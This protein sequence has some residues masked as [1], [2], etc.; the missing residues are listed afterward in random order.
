MACGNWRNNGVY[1]CTGYVIYLYIYI[2]LELKYSSIASK[3]RA[4]LVGPFGFGVDT[5]P[6]KREF[7]YRDDSWLQPEAQDMLLQN[8]PMTSLCDDRTN[9]LEKHEKGRSAKQALLKFLNVLSV[10]RGFDIILQLLEFPQVI[11]TFASRYAFGACSAYFCPQ[12]SCDHFS[13]ASSCI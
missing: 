7:M 9:K 13:T 2:K 12:K 10:I 1:L 3:S 11:S 4:R 8:V 6:C 5:C